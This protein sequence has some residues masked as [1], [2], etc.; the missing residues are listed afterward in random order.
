MT[1]VLVVIFLLAINVL[2]EMAVNDTRHQPH[3]ERTFF[4]SS[5]SPPQRH[6]KLIVSVECD[7]GPSKTH[8]GVLSYGY[9]VVDRCSMQTILAKDNA[10][11][12]GVEGSHSKSYNEKD[13]D[14]DLNIIDALLKWNPN[15]RFPS[16]TQAK[17]CLEL[18]KV[19]LFNAASSSAMY[20]EGNIRNITTITKE[21]SENVKEIHVPLIELQSHLGSINS[22]LEYHTVFV[23]VETIPR[24]DRYSSSITKHMFPPLETVGLV[25]IIYE[26]NHLAVVNKPENMT[27]IGSTGSSGSERANDLQSVLGFL[28]RPSPLDASYHPR[29][30]HRL[31]RRT[32]GLVLV[33]KTKDSMRTLSKAFAD[34]T[35][36]KT[37]SALTFERDH[38]LSNQLDVQN[39]NTSSSSIP[40]EWLIVD[41]PIEKRD[42]ISEVRRVNS[43][44]TSFGIDDANDTFSLVEVRPK[45][46]R[47]H[48]IRRHLS[49][50]LGMPIVGDSKY[51]KGARHL[52]TNGMYLCCHSLKFPHAH[53]NQDVSEVYISQD[54]TIKWT[55]ANCHDDDSTLDTSVRSES[56]LSIRIPL[57]DKFLSCTLNTVD[58]F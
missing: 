55:H 15:G 50:C 12:D 42:A 20:D 53:R 36:T 31:D 30:V 35:V 21:A 8:D 2:F 13:L 28:L 34:R 9:N 23:L 6:Q 44:T 37:Y 43:L 11:H 29:P 48:H 1:N 32:S 40:K 41:Y 17:R 4:V 46:G 39:G 56:Q 33:A 38:E 24:E 49:Y 57:P 26:D 18:G 27:T 54:A 16:K 7:H 3:V 47:I 14:R 52:R 10:K 22:V 45:T 51:D 5:F 19:L 58:E 25:P